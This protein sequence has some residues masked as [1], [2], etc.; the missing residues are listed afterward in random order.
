MAVGESLDGQVREFGQEV[1]ADAGPCRTDKRD[2][3]G[4]KAPRGE[5][6]DLR[7]H[8]IEPLRVVDDADERLLVG[9]HR[10]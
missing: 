6:E 8:L 10:E 9:D 5:S 1:V 2:A 4:E 7:G 3:L